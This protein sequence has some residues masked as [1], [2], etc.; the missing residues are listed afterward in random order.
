MPIPPAPAGFYLEPVQFPLPTVVQPYGLY[1]SIKAEYQVIGT[2][3]D[4]TLIAP[5]GETQAFTVVL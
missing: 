1:Q 4:L 2:R 3:N 5:T